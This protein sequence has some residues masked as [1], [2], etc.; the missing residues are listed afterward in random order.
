MKTLSDLKQS[1]LI[2][3]SSSLDEL[4]GGGIEKGAITQFYG[5]PGCG[6][7]NIVLKIYM[8]RLKMVLKQFIW[9]LKV[10][11]H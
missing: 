5:P 10:V 7:T 11:C 4:L 8:N 9:I 2:P 3:T 1:V 6:K